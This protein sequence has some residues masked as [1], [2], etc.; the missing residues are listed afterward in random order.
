LKGLDKCILGSSHIVRTRRK[1]R[2]QTATGI[3]D[4]LLDRPMRRLRA[5]IWIAGVLHEELRRVNATNP[6]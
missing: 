5:L 2:E 6:K 4:C 3:A 1:K